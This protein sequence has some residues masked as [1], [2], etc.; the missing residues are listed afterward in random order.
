MSPPRPTK[1][2][3]PPERTE[4]APLACLLPAA[5]KR[6]GETH[7]RAGRGGGGGG[8][9]RARVGEWGRGAERFF[10]MPRPAPKP[11]H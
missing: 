6:R 8:L 11:H 10:V 9:E 7:A 1:L 5:V 3:L 2:A 4:P